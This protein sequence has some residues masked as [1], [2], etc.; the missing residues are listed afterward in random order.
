[1]RVT[2]PSSVLPWAEAFWAV[3]AGQANGIFSSS[4]PP[5]SR[6]ASTTRVELAGASCS[7]AA[8][9]SSNDRAWVPAGRVGP[10]TPSTGTSSVRPLLRHHWRRSGS[11]LVPWPSLLAVCWYHTDR[12][13]ATFWSAPSSHT[14]T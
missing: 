2:L 7:S 10:V 9:R 11:H 13:A 8:W 6:T 4:R 12:L 3:F 1:D 14:A 5:T